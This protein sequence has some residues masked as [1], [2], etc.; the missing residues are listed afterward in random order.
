MALPVANLGYMPNMSTPSGGGHYVKP[1]PWKDLALAALSSVVQSGIKNEFSPDYTEQAQA[2]G[3]AVDPEAKKAGF[4]QK[5]LQGPTTSE[6]Q[7]GQLRGQSSQQQLEGT[8]QYG[9]SSRQRSGQKFTGG[10]NE[11]N[12]GQQEKLQGRE[13]SSAEARTQAEIASRREGQTASDTAAMDRLNL[14]IAAR[15]RELGRKL[16]ADEKNTVTRA[17]IDNV[18]NIVT[19]GNNPMAPMINET[20]TSKG[21]APLPTTDQQIQQLADQLKKLGFSVVPTQSQVPPIPMI[22]Q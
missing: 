21:M 16:T 19:K 11:K 20:L 9:E 8:R 4:I 7:L 10:E 13:L 12:R 2:E 22:Q 1:D 14:E 15:E 18:G 6:S 5:F 17:F 3:L